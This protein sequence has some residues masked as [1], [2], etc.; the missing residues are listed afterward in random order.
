M[1]EWRKYRDGKAGMAMNG[2]SLASD[3]V[4][5]DSDISATSNSRCRSIRK[6]V[7]STGRFR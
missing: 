4:Y 1:H 2:R 5:E 7:S 3:T 6:K